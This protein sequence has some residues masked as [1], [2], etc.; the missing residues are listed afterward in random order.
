MLKKY[1]IAFVS[2]ANI[3]QFVQYAHKLSGHILPATY[4]LGQN[5]IPHISL[6]HF[7]ADENDIECILR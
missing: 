6:C 7:E 3:S 2:M 4:L 5:S 1:N